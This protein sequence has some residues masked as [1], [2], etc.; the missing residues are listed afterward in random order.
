MVLFLA[1]LLMLE[2]MLL[3]VT[4]RADVRRHGRTWYCITAQYAFFVRTWQSGDPAP[5][6]TSRQ[7]RRRLLSALRQAESARRFLL[8]HVH[9][10]RLDACLLL[11]TEDAAR[12]SLLSGLLTGLAHIPAMQRRQVR[13]RVWP[14][15]FRPHSTLQ[16]RC[17]IR[18][19]MG[20]ILLTMLMLL[21]FRLRQKAR[22]AYGTSHW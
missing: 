16:A 21:A 6:Q 20:T 4:F 8:R 14:D 13:I 17:I 19:R 11:R 12:T 1:A 18:L 7:R 3:P 15:F 9:L 22:T 10:D 2:A 5:T